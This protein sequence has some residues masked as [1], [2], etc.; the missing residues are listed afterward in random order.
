MDSGK[1]YN[2]GS[3]LKFPLLEINPN[4]NKAS[5]QKQNNFNKKNKYNTIKKRISN[6]SVG[7]K[8]VNNLDKNKVN[9]YNI[10]EYADKNNNI[11]NFNYSF[12]KLNIGFN[13]EEEDIISNSLCGM[14]N[15]SNTCYI[16]SSLQ[17]LIHIPQF[18]DIIRRNNHIKKGVI[19]FINKIFDLIPDKS[20]K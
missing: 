3:F 4:Y 9:N 2:L 19:Y 7:K 17:I 13:K 5:N 16:N 6:S 11:E 14:K 10:N 12:S 15:I 1:E 20:S 18:V 8:N